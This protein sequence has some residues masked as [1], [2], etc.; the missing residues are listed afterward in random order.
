[1]RK[2]LNQILPLSD[3]FSKYCLFY[4]YDFQDR[5]FCGEPRMDLHD[6]YYN[7]IFDED[8]QEYDSENLHTHKIVRAMEVHSDGDICNGLCLQ[9]FIN[10]KD[11]LFWGCN[12]KDITPRKEN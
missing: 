7:C 4:A 12:E 8:K 3:K 11:K 6:K 9:F 10:G 5:M 1:M 2:I